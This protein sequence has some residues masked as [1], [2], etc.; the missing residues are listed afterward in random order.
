METPVE[1]VPLNCIRC[2]TSIPAEVDEVAW[3]CRQCE[4]GQQLGDDG[5]IPLRVNYSVRIKPSQ[6]GRPFWVCEG[7]VT[8][9]RNTYGTFGKKTGEALSFWELPRQFIIP[10]FTYTLGEFS[11]VG[12]KWLKTPPAME[13][14]LIVDFEPVTVASGDV[15]AWAE[16][17]VMAIE[18]ERKDKIKKIEFKLT[19]AEPQLW[20]LP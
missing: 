12:V 20:I 5:L 19:L 13:P 3:V 2:G 16:F 11:R 6:K 9:D 14:G 1:L 18:A 7:R 15:S 4:R 10:A 8:L 17:L